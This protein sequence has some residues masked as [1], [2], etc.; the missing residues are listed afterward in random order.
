MLATSNGFM[1]G[2][3][4]RYEPSP[5][6]DARH[7][8]CASKLVV[9]ER[10]IPHDFIGAADA[11]PVNI[12]DMLPSDARFKILVFTGDIGVERTMDRVRALARR[13]DAPDGF[14]KRFGKDAYEK[15]FDV[16]CICATK[17]DNMDFTGGSRRPAN[18]ASFAI[19]QGASPQT[20]RSCLG[21]TG[22][23]KR[24]GA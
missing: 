18:R 11:I 22:R 17:Q 15:M 19:S 9:G 20:Y 4:I 12:H 2:I 8:S 7:Q 16:L 5:I 14:L 21:R 23:S 6:V 3:G 1:S 13:M 10:M 24:L